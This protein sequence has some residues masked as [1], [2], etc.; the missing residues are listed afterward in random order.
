M[1]FSIFD[2]DNVRVLCDGSSQRMQRFWTFN[3]NYMKRYKLRLSY[4]YWD[5]GHWLSKMWFKLTPKCPREHLL[6]VPFISLNFISIYLEGFIKLHMVFL[7][8]HVLAIRN[9]NSM[10]N[11]VIDVLYCESFISLTRVCYQPESCWKC[12]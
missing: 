12:I 2:W 1:K 7:V 5:S 6:Y 9:W 4:F 10:A 8:G 11:I 3:S